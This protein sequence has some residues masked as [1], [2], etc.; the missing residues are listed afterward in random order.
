M[1]AARRV[2]PTASLRVPM[3]WAADAACAAHEDPEM[4]FNPLMVADAVYVCHG[5]RVRWECLE[6]AITHRELG[7]WGGT[8]DQER[9]SM[10]RRATRTKGKTA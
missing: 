10:R 8:T 3:P 9:E 1:T 7:V 2:W 6:H 4:W 5:C